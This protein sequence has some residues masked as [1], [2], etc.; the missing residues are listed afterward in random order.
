MVL[1][2]FRYVADYACARTMVD[3]TFLRLFRSN[4]KGEKGAGADG[5]F[6][7]RLGDSL[8]HVIVG[9]LVQQ[10]TDANSSVECAAATTAIRETTIWAES[11]A[12]DEKVFSR[13]LIT[14]LVPLPAN[15]RMVY[16]LRV[17]DGYSV[18]KTAQL[19]QIEEKEVDPCL[20]EARR[21]LQSTV[22]D[23]LDPGS[24]MDLKNDLTS[25]ILT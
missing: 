13:N 17:I 18:E 8:V 7:N 15:L 24:I 23:H 19:L 9:Y 22:K 6:A 10:Q 4:A 20:S 11:P 5:A 21:L 2:I 14:L 1:E 16:N 3:E 12:S 25:Q